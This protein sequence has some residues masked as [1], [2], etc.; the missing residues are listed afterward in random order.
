MKLEDVSEDQ[1]L[2]LRCVVQ[3]VDR[4]CLLYP[5]KVS[6]P[7]RTPD[8]HLFDQMWLTTKVVEDYLE[9]WAD[10]G[11]VHIEVKEGED[12]SEMAMT[13]KCLVLPDNPID[14]LS[15]LVWELS[16]LMTGANERGDV[17]LHMMATECLKQLLGAYP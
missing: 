6:V 8:G 5:V 2:Y 3:R 4:T 12:G 13:I 11:G 10:R 14:K 16:S 7:Y 17:G 9:S 1:T 15:T